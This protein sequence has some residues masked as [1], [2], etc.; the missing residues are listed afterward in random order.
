MK[1]IENH[2]QRGSEFWKTILFADGNK[3]KVFGSDGRNYVQRE[4]G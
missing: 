4:P 2:L 3:Y 1:F